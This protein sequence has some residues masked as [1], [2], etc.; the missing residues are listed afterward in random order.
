MLPESLST[1]TITPSE[2]ATSTI[3]T[4]SGD[5]TKPPACRARP[6]TIAITNETTKP[7]AVSF[8]ICPRKR[9]R[10]ISSPD[11]NSR[12]ARPTSARIETG[13]SGVT[14]PS[15]DGPMM[16]PSTIS[17]TIAG[18]RKRGKKPSAS[19][20]NRPTATTMSRLVKWTAGMGGSNSQWPGVTPRPSG[21]SLVR[22]SSRVRSRGRR[23]R[24]A[25]SGD[26]R[27]I[28]AVE[29]SHGRRLE[30]AATFPLDPSHPDKSRAGSGARI[31][32]RPRAGIGDRSLSPPQK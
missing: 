14:Q 15:P 8:R 31:D 28:T 13:R 26:H 25:P 32:S 16:I 1:G 9:C 18:S 5:L 21:P 19:G 10:S 22:C 27:L 24:R 6:N 3:A 11:R 17:S 29:P 23:S 7:S 12:N 30:G 4:N 2:V 20:A